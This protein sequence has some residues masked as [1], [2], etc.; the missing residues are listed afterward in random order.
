MAKSYASAVIP[1]SVEQVWAVVRDFDGLPQWHPAI[2]SSSLADGARPTEV[3]A[4]RELALPDGGQIREQ[5]VALDDVE[6]SL[7]YEML[8]G[9]FPIRSYRATV[10]A[11]PVSGGQQCF[12]EWYAHYDA[13]AADEAELDKT[14]G[15]GVFATGLRG[16]NQKFES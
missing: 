15:Q 13:E 4:V 9:P 12:V 8:E 1:A 14:F 2:S 16:L 10:R 5:L 11:F 3:G 6:R 7:S